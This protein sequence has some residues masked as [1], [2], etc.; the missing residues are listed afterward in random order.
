VLSGPANE[1]I[2]ESP[3]VT[4]QLLLPVLFGAVLALDLSDGAT[5]IQT[6]VHDQGLR[7]NDRLV[8]AT[9]YPQAD[10]DQWHI[11][12]QSLEGVA[13]AALRAFD[14]QH[15]HMGL[16]D[17]A[18]SVAGPVVEYPESMG[19]VDLSELHFDAV[20]GVAVGSQDVQAATPRMAQFL[21]KHRHLA[22]AEPCRFSDEPVL[23]PPLVI[24]EISKA[25]GLAG[26]DRCTRFRTLHATNSRQRAGST[27]ASQ[28]SAPP[29]MIRM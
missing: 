8:D 12:G 24:A 21:G 7:N 1:R 3:G 16:V 14:H 6:L 5:N 20:V 2:V 18:S 17:I 23:Q 10:H 22:E 15:G 13:E 27:A 4:G 9:P 25:G 19:G 26:M 29:L 28:A 11:L